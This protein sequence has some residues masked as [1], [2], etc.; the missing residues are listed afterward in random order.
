M[1]R[2]LV[3]QITARNPAELVINERHKGV[4]RLLVSISPFLQQ[5]GY[6]FR[7]RWRQFLASWI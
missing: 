2:L 4:K 6:L 1:V 3:L 7:L 5:F